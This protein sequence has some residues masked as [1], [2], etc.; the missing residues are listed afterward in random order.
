[1]T[2]ATRVG[3]VLSGRDPSLAGRLA[4]LLLL[5]S[6]ALGAWLMAVPDRVMF[7][8]S[9]TV[10]LLHVVL[11]TLTAPFVVLWALRHAWGL[12]GRA[13]SRPAQAINGALFAVT[14]VALGT[15]AVVVWSGEI[16]GAHVWHSSAAL[17]MGFAL[18]GHLWG[19]GR[20]GF[21]IGLALLVLAAGVA[22]R[23]ARPVW[24]GAIDP[25]APEFAFQT[26]SA[27]LYESAESCGECHVDEFSQWRQSTHGATMHNPIFVRDMER[28]PS[29]LGFDMDS[30]GALAKGA[31]HTTPTVALINS[32]ERCHTPTSFYGDDH[33]DALKAVGVAS[34][35]VTCSFCHT[36]RAV[37]TGLA[38]G[39]PLPPSVGQDDL[40]S[41]L[42]RLPYYVSA[43]QTVR[44]YLGEGSRSRIARWISNALIRWRPSVHR[45]DM[46]A[47][48]LDDAVACMPCHSSGDFDSIPELA[49]K[50][51]VSWEHS[52]FSTGDPRTTVTCQDCHMATALTGAKSS[53]LGTLVPWGPTREHRVSH[54]LLGGNRVITDKLDERAQSKQEHE[55][56]RRVVE[57]NMV[58]SRPVNRWIEV[59]VEAKSRF[60]GHDLPTSAAQNRWLW[61]QFSAFDA[62]GT[63]LSETRPPKA[64]DDVGSE[65][66]LIFRCTEPPRPD[67]NTVLHPSVPQ[68][69]TA[70]LSLPEG[71]VPSRVVATLWASFDDEPLASVSAPF[72]P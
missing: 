26:Q 61:I 6:L 51:Y 15:G 16:G 5:P 34:E 8:V 71:A 21:S 1:V 29:S 43:P 32:C 22:G 56:N 11:A 47:P 37:H 65:S 39:Q 46:H 28:Q 40:G 54:L 2:A 4:A 44:R 35:G 33:G 38:R 62:A 55:M 3:S 36:I 12:R 64:K 41:I 59:S 23:V 17:A 72:P 49:Q 19:P 14:L 63:R 27:D 68:R 69:F 52:Q 67:C 30:Y 70:R 10:T 53:E 42:P 18:A 48:V 31:P 24:K 58:G 45:A 57:L 66:P 7:G 9:E 25:R 50:T 13:R 60:V 20:R